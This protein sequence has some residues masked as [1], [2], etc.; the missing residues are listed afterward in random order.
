MTGGVLALGLAIVLSGAGAI[1][2][3]AASDHAPG[4]PTDLRV[5]EAV[6]PLWVT[7]TPTFGW[8]PVD[9]DRDEIQTAYE[10]VVASAPTTD[11]NASTVLADTGRVSSSAESSVAVA[12]LRLKPDHRY[13]WT[14]RTWDRAG[15]RGAFAKPQPFDTALGDGDWHADW[16]RRPEPPSNPR[17]DY[18]LLRD[19]FTVGG[20]A[21]VRARAYLSAAQQ[22]ELYVNGT[23]VGGG[24][25]YSYPDEQY[26]TSTDIAPYLKPGLNAIGM[27]VHNLGPGQ[28]RPAEPPGAIAHLTIDHRDGFRQTFT[29]SGRWRVHEGPWLPATARNDEGDYVENIDA[30]LL[31]PSWATASFDDSTWEHALVVGAHPVAPW[32]HLI[33]QRTQIVE[34]PVKPV[35]FRRLANGAYVADF[36]S[37]IAATPQISLHAGIA[38][39]AL[40]LL[41]GYLLDPGG[42]VSTTKGTQET[43]MHDSYVERAGPQTLRPFGY[44]GFRYVELTNPGEILHASDVVAYA[45]HAG[46]PGDDASTFTSSSPI[47]NRIWELARH[48]ALY[49]SQ[50]QFVDTPTRERGQ[51]GQDSSNTS[52]VTQVA[53]AERNLTWQALRDFARSQKRYW[54]DGR[55]NAVYPNGDGKRDIPDLT[56]NY[57]IWVMRYYDITGDRSELA[58]LYPVIRN[59]ASYVARA[60]SPAA[61]LVTNLPG[62]GGDYNGGIVDW[63]IQERFGYDMTTVARTT[64]S[65]IA[66]EMF[67]ELRDAARALH[68]PAREIDAYATRATALTKAVNTR[69]RRP[70]GVYIDGLHQNGTQS[71][72][73]SQQANAYA[74]AAG[75]VPASDRETVVAHVEQLGMATGPDIAA[76]L[77]QGL[78]AS[79]NDD[80]LVKLISNPKIPGWAQILSRGATFTWESWDA[81]DVYGDSES[82]AWGS[83]VL[84][85]LTTDVLGV[86][87]TKPG[88]SEVTVAPPTLS[89]VTS[90]RGRLA[91]ERGPVAVAWKRIDATHFKL[92]VTVPDN[93][94]AHITVPAHATSDVFENGSTVL[95]SLASGRVQDGTL[96][97]TV[98]SG[99]YSLDIRPRPIAD[100]VLHASGSSSVGR[101]LAFVVGALVLLFLAA[102]FVAFARRRRAAA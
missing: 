35:S 37:V 90:A 6:A 92:D 98:G 76:V 62:G 15:T 53:F 83:T 22:Y 38:G 12:H 32:T 29:T 61:G 7:A 89:T 56:E 100:D 71:T 44:L 67:R 8:I 42:A 30:R 102:A 88:A 69:L 68:R 65:I 16:I 51:F 1:G 17:E 13:W 99:Q 45:R 75:I 77:L 2:A 11:P 78:H 81:R 57:P 3:G 33:A 101:W 26:Y 14:V 74:L 54:P 28:G 24:P 49:G 79:G 91:T 18:F 34:K 87:V 27:I 55:V 82:H 19:T 96:R 23:R 97:F 73:A 72:H 39:R 64:E 59:V 41:Q 66:I 52:S 80:A 36:G 60:I 58:T 85:A 70:D 86:S 47:L 9:T 5:D 21:I 20:S 84:P 50:E 40:T 46:M 43:D 4:S 63:P 25:S 48:S 94:V 10:V 95:A 31:P 93:V